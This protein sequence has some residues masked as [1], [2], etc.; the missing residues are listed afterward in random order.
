MTAIIS[1]D[2]GEPPSGSYLEAQ[3]GGS[4][5]R[6]TGEGILGP[7]YS[8]GCQ[9]SHAAFRRRAVRPRPVSPNRP[10]ARDT[11]ADGS[12]AAATEVTVS[13]ALV[14]P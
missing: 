3:M 4:Q 10:S 12:G 9:S 6:R 1:I 5:L 8:L 14:A 7:S 2:L 11:M 13:D